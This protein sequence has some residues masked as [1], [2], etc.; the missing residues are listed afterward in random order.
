LQ[1]I[2]PKSYL[3]ELNFLRIFQVEDDGVDT[4][5]VADEVVVQDVVVVMTRKLPNAQI[6]SGSQVT[7][8]TRQN[9]KN[10]KM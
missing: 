1:K 6:A 5:G 10:N 2:E 4:V 7:L 8:K 9:I 3:L